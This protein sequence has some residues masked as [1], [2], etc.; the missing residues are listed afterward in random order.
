MGRMG[1]GCAYKSECRFLA[2]KEELVKRGMGDQTQPGRHQ[3]NAW[4]VT[5][6]TQELFKLPGQSPS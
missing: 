3:C 2:G 5:F 6:A 1:R 4:M